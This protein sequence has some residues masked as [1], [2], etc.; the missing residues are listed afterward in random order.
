MA[1]IKDILKEGARYV[2]SHLAYHDVPVPLAGP[3]QVVFFITSACNARCVMC[4]IYGRSA[5][6]DILSLREITRLLSDLGDMGVRYISF[7]G[8]EPFMRNDLFEILHAA[9]DSG[10][11]CH[12]NTNGMLITEQLLVKIRAS[13]LDGITVAI[14]GSTPAVHDAIKGV[15]GS[16]EK[17]INGVKLL[18]ELRE[19]E[20]SSLN[21]VGLGAIILRENL[22]DLVAIAERGRALGVDKVRYQ[23]IDILPIKNDEEAVAR[24]FP[25]RSEYEA[26]ER[27]I[28]ALIAFK[29]T[30]G[31]ISNSVGFLEVTKEYL[32]GRLYQNIPCYAGFSSVDVDELG[33]VYPCYFF[34]SVGSIRERSFKEIWRSDEFKAAREK[35]KAGRCGKCW[36]SCHAE[37]SLL[38]HAKYGP[39]SMANALRRRIVCTK[40]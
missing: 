4:N 36:T 9:K 35:I 24:F 30:R 26:M 23:P 12:V 1:R 29:K 28:D 21:Q 17:A 13:G 5:Q 14:D 8:G 10:L 22:H 39:A 3:A 34:K 19:E 40:N 11:I 2:S 20:G 15:A 18:V 37:V 7:T 38:H 25:A 31:T 6:Q 16:F 32:K 33:N 27:T